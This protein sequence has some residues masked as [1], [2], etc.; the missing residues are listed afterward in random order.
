MERLKVSQVASLLGI[1]ATAV[2]R[3]FKTSS[4]LIQNQ[5]HKIDGVTYITREGFEL[6]KNNETE[7]AHN[8]E[9][10][11]SCEPVQNLVQ[12]LEKR[13]IEQQNLI[14]NF[15]K[16]IDDLISKHTNTIDN[17][18]S[19]HAEER[20]RHDAILMRLTQNIS[21]LQKAL[22]YRQSE[23]KAE[24]PAPD[25]AECHQP[26]RE[27]FPQRENTPGD[28]LTWLQRAW[29]AFWSPE[30]LRVNEC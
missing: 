18:I 23:Q 14:A 10:S 2:Y 1:T 13:V 5:V 20:A 26:E 16:T 22:E 24:S 28:S 7:K 12:T 29:L 8:Q 6:L 21:S 9:V 27:K 19:T 11:T 30:E 3:K 4:E 15:Q 25:R 17:L